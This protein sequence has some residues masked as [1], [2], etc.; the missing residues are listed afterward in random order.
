MIIDMIF[1]M[2]KSRVISDKKLDDK[3]LELSFKGFKE[4]YDRYGVKVVGAWECIDNPDV[5]YLITAYHDI[6][7]YEE[8]VEKMREN[9]EYRALTQ[10]RQKTFETIEIATMKPMPGTQD[11]VSP[12]QRFEIV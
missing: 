8:T 12:A 10:E 1:K 4:I 2:Y 3:E 6:T 11:I 7:H 5:G 9:P